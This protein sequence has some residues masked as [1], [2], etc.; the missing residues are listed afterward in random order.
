MMVIVAL[1][2]SFLLGMAVICP[3][4]P[5]T[6]DKND[7]L[8]RIGQWSIALIV[9]TGLSGSIFAALILWL[10]AAAGGIVYPDLILHAVLVVFFLAVK[11]SE[12]PAEPVPVADIPVESETWTEKFF[13]LVVVTSIVTSFLMVL[14]LPFGGQ[15][16]MGIWNAK[17]RVL[18]LARTDLKTV[19]ANYTNHPDYPL[20][21]PAA[22]ARLWVFGSNTS[23]LIP[24]L[25]QWIYTY[26]CIFIVASTVAA[27]H[28]TRVGMLAG[29]LLAGTPFFLREGAAAQQADV[30]LAAM[31]V[32]ALALLAF[33]ELNKQKNTSVR[34]MVLTGV[35][36]GLSAWT[37]NEGL[38]FIA[39]LVMAVSLVNIR[40]NG[41]RSWL[42]EIIAFGAGALPI[43]ALIAWFKI[44]VGQPTDIFAM[45]DWKAVI[46]KLIDPRRHLIV[47]LG[48]GREMLAPDRWQIYPLAMMT[49][50]ILVGG[51]AYQPLKT[52]LVIAVLA[53]VFVLSGYYCVYV[54]TPLDLEYHLRT[55]IHRI[56]LHLWPA[57]IM[58]FGLGFG[59]HDHQTR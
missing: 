5:V 2:S 43:L 56:L 20:L 25:I 44:S 24:L 31:I 6:V 57:T 3:C 9:G 8:S 53:M 42:K 22:V 1:A 59:Y 11:R 12:K 38:L 35:V 28:G 36:A 58:T 33:H 54:I 4:L 55:S 52:Y 47:A 13:W 37:K 40:K 18:A 41:V 16:A 50:I 7:P 10:G 49:W 48:M 17:A 19:L 23:W 46:G 45:Q 26:G 30:V 15:D 14:Q 34:L 21:L 32:T 39:S 27:V 29:L 51:R